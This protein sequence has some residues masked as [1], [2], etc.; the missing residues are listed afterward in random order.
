MVV[1]A[2][3]TPWERLVWQATPDDFQLAHFLLSSIIL[4]AELIELLFKVL[5]HV[6]GVHGAIAVLL[7]LIDILVSLAN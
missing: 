3:F 2:H 5:L 4:V 1:F 7:N 6:M